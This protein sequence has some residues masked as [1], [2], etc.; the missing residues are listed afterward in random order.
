MHLEVY[1]HR[2]YG[3]GDCCCSLSTYNMS[4]QIINTGVD[5]ALRSNLVKFRVRK[6]AHS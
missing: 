4:Q 1:L 2:I 6:D 3:F 5:Q